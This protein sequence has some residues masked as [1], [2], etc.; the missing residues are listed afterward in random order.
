MERMKF[1]RYSLC[2]FGC[3]DIPMVA[4]IIEELFSDPDTKRFFVVSDEDVDPLVF[5]Q[6]M[7]NVNEQH[8]GID[9]IVRDNDQNNIGLLGGLFILISFS[10]LPIRITSPL[11][12]TKLLLFNK[13]SSKH[14][15]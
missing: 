13:D 5:A 3:E 10:F 1:G 6:R 2:V 9:C 4:N 15:K 7:A 11:Y 14:L 12:F 8:R